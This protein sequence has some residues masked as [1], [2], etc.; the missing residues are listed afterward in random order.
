[1]VAGVD[2]NPEVRQPFE[3]EV[4]ALLGK[5][6]VT[7]TASHT[8]F[9]FDQLKGNKQQLAQQLVAAKVESLLFVRVTGKTDFVEGP[10]P[11]LADMDIGAVQ[12]DGYIAFTQPPGGEMNTIYNLGARFFRVSDG[13]VIWS[14]VLNETLKDGEDRLYF[15]R[16]TARTIVDRLAK[17]K[18]I[19]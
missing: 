13:A 9:S 18:V 5:R 6:G 1:M 12:E 17:D 4:V 19:P 14:G 7:A 11:D 15:I 8:M 16:Q 10:P 3:N 2:Q